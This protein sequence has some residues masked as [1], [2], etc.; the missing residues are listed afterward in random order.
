MTSIALGT[1]A[2][3]S[4]TSSI[5]SP[6]AT[7]SWSSSRCL[8]RTHQGRELI[9]LK[10][11]QG[12]QQTPDGSRPAVLYSS[13]QH[14]REWISLEVNRRL[15]HYFIDRWRAGDRRI[16][17][18]LRRTELW[19]VISANPDGYQYTFDS[20]RLWRKNLRDNDGDGQ[21][22]IADGVDPN[23]NFAEHWGYDNEGSSPDPADETYR[24]P[25]AASE[26]ETRAMQGL[27]DRIEPRFQSNLHSFGE[28]LLYP[29]GWQV[30]TL[31]ADYP[32]YV[33]TGGTDA[34]SAIPGFNPGQSADTLYVTNGETTDYADI[35]AGTISFTPELGEGRPGAGFVFPDDEG[36][37]QAEFE[38]TLDFH[39]GL[40]WSAAS[41]ANPASPV[42]IGV[43]PFYLDADDIDP[44]NGQTS[45][46]DF[47]FDSS[48]GDPQE[49][50]VLAKR[51]LGPVSLRYRINGG[52]DPLCDDERMARG[53]A[54]RGR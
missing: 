16:K 26:P 13:N 52:R 9:A 42:G 33:A 4:A 11:T 48:Y 43:E 46:F 17:R 47:K 31:D 23:R 41:P 40:A 19:F 45:L 2:G 54:L 10:L 53:R 18:L 37:I 30:G 22:S 6:G 3:A 25:S 1:S 32:I 34:D 35:N 7:R 21:I 5:A 20:E 27:I 29:Q 51:S 44:Q 28:W 8:G 49:V 39:L 12:A 38:K 15:L 14:A 36:L 50:R 24:G